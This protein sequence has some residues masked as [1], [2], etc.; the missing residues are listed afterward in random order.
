VSRREKRGRSDDY[1]HDDQDFEWYP[2]TQRMI[3]AVA[4][5]ITDRNVS[6]L[7]IGAGDGRVL[8]S[9]G[10]HCQAE[11]LYAIEKSPIL[12]QSQPDNVVPVGTDLFEQNLACL[13]VDYIFCNPPYSQYETWATA[14]ID[15]RLRQTGVPRHPPAV[16]GFG[17]HPG[18]L[19]KRGATARVIHSDDFPRR[20]AAGAGR[21]GHR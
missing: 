17:G 8:L 15:V 16:E 9:L 2:T 7:D 6:L 1:E 3:D 4:K 19:K 12:V 18:S 11:S 14:I 5:R 10:K 13:P 20:R 21:G